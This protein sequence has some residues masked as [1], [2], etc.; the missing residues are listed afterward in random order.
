[1]VRETRRAG[2]LAGSAADQAKAIGRPQVDDR[3]SRRVLMV[4][5]HFPPLG[6][7]AVPRSICNVRYLPDFRWTPIVVA[8][9]DGGGLEDPDLHALIPPQTKVYRA[10]CP[11][12][13]H[14][15]RVVDPVR[16]VLKVS[17][18]LRR[19]PADAMSHRGESTAAPQFNKGPEPDAAPP[20]P[21]WLWRLHR[22]VTFPD[23]QVGWLP[24]ALKSALRACRDQDCDA[25]FSSSAPITAHLVAGIVKRLTGLPWV[26]EFRDPWLGNPITEALVGPR[27]WLHR[28]LQVRLERWIIRSADRIV[29]VSPSTARLYRRRYPDAQIV[30]ITNGHDRTEVSLRSAHAAKP[31]QYRIV[32]TGTVRPDE[33]QTFLEA[34]EGVVARRSIL[35][36]QLQV[37]FYG[38]V[39]DSCRAVAE[40]FTRDGLLG[41]VVR[42]CGFVPRRVA[43]EALAD[44]DAA[45]LMLGAGAGI[46]Q[47]IPAKLFDILG[48]NQQVL[49]I[50]PPGDARYILEDLAWGILAEPDVPDV[51]RAIELL[52]TLP[53]PTRPADPEGRFDRFA[54]AGRLADTL[55]EATEAG[56]GART[57]RS[58]L[59]TA[60]DTR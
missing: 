43:L 34:L 58:G 6:G 15:R 23:N 51:E 29:F 37:A 47:Q 60:G 45:L 31:N 12:P 35:A 36:E 44:A 54:L 1:M 56:H 19:G 9:R 25:I 50:L 46:G 14:F 33:L 22:L 26:A 2:R 48:Q 53:R 11:E 32:Y 3:P 40:R 5:F 49:A 24:F 59:P 28:R 13:R 57:T 7:V 52:L 16:A 41:G 55:R 39:S 42:F 27:P 38:D 20:A 4:L 21:T 8:P 17:R 30:T 18:G 10:W